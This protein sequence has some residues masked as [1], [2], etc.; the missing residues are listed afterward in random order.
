MLC[1]QVTWVL[2]LLSLTQ[3]DGRGAR[4][5]QLRGHRSSLCPEGGQ[6]AVDGDAGCPDSGSSR[7]KK[8][9]VAWGP[10]R[11]DRGPH[12]MHGARGRPDLRAAGP[13]REV[14]QEGMCPRGTEPRGE[15]RPLAPGVSSC[16]KPGGHARLAFWK[17]KQFKIGLEIPDVN[18]LLESCLETE[19]S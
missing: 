15:A 6:P 1:L 4:P 18:V 16:Q 7:G 8:T 12:R 9:A 3:Q 17:E 2:L 13:H 11:R 10:P 14:R 19:V 5:L